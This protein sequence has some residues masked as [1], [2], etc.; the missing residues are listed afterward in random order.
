MTENFPDTN[1]HCADIS[2]EGVEDLKNVMAEHQLGH[3]TT[4]DIS[5]K[6]LNDYK[7]LSMDIV[8]C[9]FGL[10]RF[11]NPES[12]LQ[13]VH[14]VLRPDGS[15]IVTTW[16]ITTLEQIGDEILSRVLVDKDTHIITPILNLSL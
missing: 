13:E 5:E 3:V 15:F 12:I 10:N 7:D 4:T 2:S 11:L 6:N 1:I 16:D 8:S 9:S 14:R